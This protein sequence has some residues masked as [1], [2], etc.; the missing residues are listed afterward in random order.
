MAGGGRHG[1][2]CG[3]HTQQGELPDVDNDAERCAALQERREWNV[4]DADNGHDCRGR[5][6]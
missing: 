6:P 5:S 1:V 2:E 3:L 4:I